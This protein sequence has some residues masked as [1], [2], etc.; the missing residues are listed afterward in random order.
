[1]QKFAPNDATPP[2][3]F[4]EHWPGDAL[5]AAYI[6]G[7]L[8]Q[9][10]RRR[11]ERHLGSCEDC[12]AVYAETVR[13]QLESEPAQEE[14]PAAATGEGIVVPFP[15]KEDV[16]HPRWWYG[17]AA[18]LVVGIG[19]GGV[20]YALLAPPQPLSTAEL[21]APVQ[22]KT[23]LGK[24]LWRGPTYRGGEGLGDEPVDVAVFRLGVQLVNLQVSLEANQG[25][26]SRDIL[27]RILAILRDQLLV[28]HLIEG[29]TDIK[30]AIEDGTPAETFVEQASE[31]A[32]DTREAF[33]ENRSLHLGQ[34][35]EAGLLAAIA[36]E[37][38]YFQDGDRRLFLR[39]LLWR[40]KLGRD[41][42]KLDPVALQSLRDVS[43]VLETKDLGSSDY[44]KLRRSFEAILDVYYP[45]S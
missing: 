33:L 39:R 44:A 14:E 28:T 41:D 19:I 37:P 18:L 11:I 10:E 2:P 36:Q 43:E 30:V 1:M 27:L 7:H 31:L 26:D 42:L 34:W 20:Y 35:V 21:A 13:F 32:L 17:I 22:G 6:D 15:S 8:G 4:Q 5:L 3:P 9:A 29:Y 25:E 12:Y 45:Q 23:G 40:Q 38:S 16:K 24:E